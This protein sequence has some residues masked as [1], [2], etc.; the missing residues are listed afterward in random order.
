M[1]RI[2]YFECLQ[3]ELEF[4]NVAFFLEGARG[5]GLSYKKDGAACRTF[6]GL[7]QQFLVPLRMFSLES[8]SAGAFGPPFSALSRKKI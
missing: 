4:R 3:I 5:E 7:E 8:S 1:E 2:F 6:Q